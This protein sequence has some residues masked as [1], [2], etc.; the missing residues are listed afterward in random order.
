MLKRIILALSLL[1]VATTIAVAV[2][3]GV[4]KKQADPT[5]KM[6]TVA[7]SGLD[8]SLLS[9]TPMPD[10][11]AQIVL[12]YKNGG[13]RQFTSRWLS[14]PAN[15]SNPIVDQNGIVVSATVPS[16]LGT[17]ID[18]YNTQLQSLLTTAAAA[19]KLDL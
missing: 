3:V 6:A 18:S 9:S 10:G 13:G 1:T 14:V 2:P 19:G 12:A 8:A 16:A 11:S 7:G 17:A 15:R 4:V 5:K